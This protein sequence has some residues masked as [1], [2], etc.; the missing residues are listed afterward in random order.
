[1]NS[2][3]VDFIASKQAAGNLTLWFY[4]YTSARAVV[5]IVAI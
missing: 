2:G 4:L 5:V 3:T 1:M